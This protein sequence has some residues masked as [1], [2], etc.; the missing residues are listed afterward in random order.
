MK[1]VGSGVIAIVV[2]FT[3]ILLCYVFDVFVY[4]NFAPQYEQARYNTF[5]QS[6]AF[7]DSVANDVAKQY[8]EYKK[9]SKEDQAAINALS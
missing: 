5:K 1:D 9:A 8:A 2:V 4:K 7:N 6:Q 3:L